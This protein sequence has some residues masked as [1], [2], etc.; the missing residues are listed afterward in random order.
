MIAEKPLHVA[1]F[2]PRSAQDAFWGPAEAFAKA[3]EQQL[4]IVI[5][6]YYSRDSRKRMLENLLQAKEDGVDAVIFPNFK[7]NAYEMIRS[8]ER[9]QLPVFLLNADITDKNRSLI[10]E[11]QQKYKYWLASLIPADESAGYLL[12]KSLIK[13]ARELELQNSDGKVN[14][15]AINGTLADSPA[16][17]RLKGLKRAVADDGNVEILQ[18]VHSY[19]RQ[20][21]ARYQANRLFQR[22]PVIHVYWAASDL[23]AIGINEALSKQQ[24]VQEKDYVTG[25]I[26]WSEEGIKAIKE[27]RIYTS[28]GGHFMDAA[29][30]VLMLH[31]YFNG[32]PLGKQKQLHYVSQMQRLNL[33]DIEIL[34]SRIQQSNWQ[35]INFRKKSKYYNSTLIEHSFVPSEILNEIRDLD[36]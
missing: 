23:I 1:L 29:W 9:L 15:V 4:N 34:Q 18:S 25:G 35:G 30:A 13:R 8:A 19:W 33:K 12:G 16:I 17:D 6:V 31:D 22:F 14:I 26:D 2:T 28:I 24:Q 10:G 20:D 36:E 27:H 21:T 32:I 7:R 11:P 3:T 5:S